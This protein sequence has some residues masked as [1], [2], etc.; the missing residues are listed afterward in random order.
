MRRIAKY[1]ALTAGLPCSDALMQS[2]TR[3]SLGSPVL[4]F[5]H[6]HAS[7]C[8]T[9][10]PQFWVKSKKFNSYIKEIGLKTCESLPIGYDTI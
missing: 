5:V 8:V 4:R 7:P 2:A 6:D 10:H 3:M 9:S 1:S